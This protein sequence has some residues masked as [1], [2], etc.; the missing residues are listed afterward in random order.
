MYGVELIPTTAL[1]TDDNTTND[2]Y[3]N[4]FG[5]KGHTFI[6]GSKRELTIDLQKLP[7]QSAYDWTWSQRKN[8]GTFDATSFVRSSSAQ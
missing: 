7:K 3:N 2:V 5:V 6:L 1:D 8:A 4:V